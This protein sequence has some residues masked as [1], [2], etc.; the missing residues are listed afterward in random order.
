MLCWPVMDPTAF[1]EA[2]YFCWTLLR[3]EFG[4]MDHV[5]HFIIFNLHY[6]GKGKKKKLAILILLMKGI[7]VYMGLGLNVFLQIRGRPGTNYF[8]IVSAQYILFVKISDNIIC[9]TE[10]LKIYFNITNHRAIFLNINFFFF[11]TQYFFF[12]YI[13]QCFALT[14][15]I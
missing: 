9:L 12:F 4:L 8:R 2:V 3:S 15:S 14:T 7:E 13:K 11:Q 5:K 6:L 1:F 10:S